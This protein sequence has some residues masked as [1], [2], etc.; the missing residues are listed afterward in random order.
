MDTSLSHRGPDDRGFESYVDRE[1]RPACTFAHR[2]LSILDLSHAGHQP[3]RAVS[4]NLTITYNGEVYNFRTLRDELIAAGTV[5]RSDSDTEVI[6]QGFARHGTEFLARMRGMF[7]F[8]LYDSGTGVGYL[9]R[10]PFGIKPLFLSEVDGSVLFASEVR[11]ILASGLVARRISTGALR[12]Y[13]TYGSASE[14]MTMVDGVRALPPGTV[15]RLT[16]AADGR[17]EMS[18]PARFTD[19]PFAPRKKDRVEFGPGDAARLLRNTLRDSV[20]HHLVSDVPVGIF[21]PGGIDSSAILALASEVSEARL[22][23]YTVTFD[24]ADFSET[25]PARAMARRYGTRHHEIPLRGHSL[26]SMLPDA[27]AAM[28][29]PSMDGL[30]TFAI[31]RAVRVNGPKVVL[32]GLG[33]DELFAGYPSFERA[34]RLRRLYNLPLAKRVAMFAAHGIRGLTAEKLRILFSE[35]DPARGAYRASRALFGSRIVRILA[36]HG[37]PAHLPVP[38]EGLTLLQRVTWYEATGYMLNTLLR[39]SDV[40]SMAH[41]LELRVPFVDTKV[42]RAA[43]MIPDDLRLRGGASKPMLVES[44]RDLLIEEVWNRPKQGF[45]LPFERW[46]HNELLPEVSRTFVNEEFARV[47]IDPEAAGGVWRSFLGG[48]RGM[49]WSRPWA[50]YTLMRWARQNDVSVDGDEGMGRRRTPPSIVKHAKDR[51]GLRVHLWA[52]GMFGFKGGIQVYQL[53]LLR[54]LQAVLPDA[55]ISVFVKNDREIPADVKGFERVRFRFA[56]ASSEAVR[57]PRYLS[58]I[59]RAGLTERPDLI[60]AGHLNFA[61]AAH[62][63]RRLAGVRYWIITYGVEAW[64]VSKP[65]LRQALRAADRVLSVSHHTRARLL[66]EQRLNPARVTLLSPTFDA[67][68]FCPSSKPEHLLERYGLRPDQKVIL[69]VAR[70]AGAERY[71]GYDGILEALPRMLDAAPEFCDLRYVLV[72]EGDDRSRIE[73]RI[74]ELGLSKSVT[75]TGFVADA[76]LADHYNLCDVFAMPSKREGFGI[77]YLE[78]AACGKPVIGGKLDGAVDALNWGQFGALVDPDSLNDIAATLIRLLRRDFPSPLMND[79]EAL[80]IAVVEKYGVRQFQGALAH[81]LNSLQGTTRDGAAFVDR[82]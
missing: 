9:A 50:L 67:D 65:V 37:M 81:E 71:K 15:A 53:D 31:S 40:F 27:F 55:E 47:G 12:S 62:M 26:L 45:T 41:G 77:V 28:D 32:S 43:A 68:A 73:Q 79:A 24:E 21:L 44:M 48:K 58:Q 18:E 10:D 33:G 63:I 38:P 82:S 34:W 29:Q 13:L 30:N 25:G 46:L 23:S 42:A 4:G 76:E 75:L 16:Y 54:A 66:R 36:G 49:N 72:G 64:N 60:I 78:A 14:P 6:L 80:R 8:A 11:A 69:T 56:G 7:A 20:A 51:K 59:L 57:T 3:M 39:D 52:P 70:L 19:S 17:V 5:F 35:T 22:D 1:G 2:R 61:G 74:R